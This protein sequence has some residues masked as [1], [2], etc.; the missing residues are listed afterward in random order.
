MTLKGKVILSLVISSI[1]TAGVL[2][3]LTFAYFQN[4]SFPLWSTLSLL[5]VTVVTMT[6][7][8]W[9]YIAL[10]KHQ[11]ALNPKKKKYRS[12]GNRKE[13]RRKRL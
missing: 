3:L 4:P 9:Y 5:G 1:L 10:T 11:E 6:S 12:T 8:A 13:S 2:A 7:W